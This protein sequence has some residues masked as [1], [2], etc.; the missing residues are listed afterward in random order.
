MYRQMMP[1]EIK[2]L[3]NGSMV[4]VKARKPT[5]TME[6]QY[7]KQGGWL[8]SAPWGKSRRQ[9]TMWDPTV[10][11]WADDADFRGRK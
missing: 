6:A 5:E 9:I 4:T 3:R 8:I 2:R 1:T 10:E 7:R 11:Y